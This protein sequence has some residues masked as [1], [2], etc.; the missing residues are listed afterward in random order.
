M[1]AAVKQVYQASEFAD[2]AGVTVRTLHHYDRLGLLKPSGRT[3]AGY[4]LYGERDFA[5]LQQIV[6]LK[7]IGFPLNQIKKLLDRKDFDLAK[8]L[9]FQR[10]IIEEKRKQLEDAIK[11]IDWAE[12]VVNSTRNPGPEA[13]TRI[14][15]VINMSKDM[16]WTKKYYSEEAQKAIAS[17]QVPREVIEKGQRDWAQLIKEVEASLGEDPASDKVQALAAR[18]VELVRGFTGGNPAIQED[19]NKM[20]KD[21]TNWPSGFPKPFSDEVQQFMCT[22]VSV[23]RQKHGQ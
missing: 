1:S 19:L 18:W 23:Y 10:R 2:R 5:R 12:Y 17:R 8:A 20:Y 13:F 22:A 14:I 21:L 15:E 6:T 11:A 16:E 9:R 7:F 3:A 4:R